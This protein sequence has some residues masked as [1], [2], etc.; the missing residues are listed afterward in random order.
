MPPSWDLECCSTHKN[1][2]LYALHRKKKNCDC[3]ESVNLKTFVCQKFTSFDVSPAKYSL[4]VICLSQPTSSL[5]KSW[6]PAENEIF[7][8]LRIHSAFRLGT[9]RAIIYDF[10]ILRRHQF[11][12]T[13]F[14][15]CLET[16]KSFSGA[17]L[18]GREIW[19]PAQGST[20]V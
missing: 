6:N 9:V 15:L 14:I 16:A 5:R 1:S 7:C 2:S 20:W 3:T 10:W 4:M 18:Q 17:S 19:A 11:P 8:G 13:P 12:W